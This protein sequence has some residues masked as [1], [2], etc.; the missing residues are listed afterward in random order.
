[1]TD[2]KTQRLYD[3]QECA[4]QVKAS[5]AKLEQQQKPGEQTGKGSKT[6]VLMAAKEEIQN[7]IK[8]GYTA[9]QIAEALHGDVFG[10]L[11]KTI[12]QLFAT[13][14]KP[15]RVKQTSQPSGSKKTNTAQ[16]PA[17]TESKAVSRP[18]TFTIRKDSVDL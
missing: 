16:A 3:I 10:I 11:P 4:G 18:G 5:L 2:R 13:T 7:L 1:M 6:D 9:K 14:K 12:T 15:K 17:S 8:K